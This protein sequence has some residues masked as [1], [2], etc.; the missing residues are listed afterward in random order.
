MPCA[1]FTLINGAEQLGA[2]MGVIATMAIMPNP[3][4]TT[5]AVGICSA[6]PWTNASENVAVIGPEATPPASNPI[7][8]NRSGTKNDK[9]TDRPN[10]GKR[11]IQS[12]ISGTNILSADMKIEVPTATDINKKYQIAFDRP[13]GDLFNL[14]A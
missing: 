10:P 6:M 3:S 1:S 5:S 14:M 7:P 12:F 2:I 13:A 4:A 8:T 11:Y 9:A